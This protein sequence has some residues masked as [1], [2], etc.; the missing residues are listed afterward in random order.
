MNI[1]KLS[2]DPRSFGDVLIACSVKPVYPY[3]NG[4]RVSDEVTNL[5]YEI[6]CPAIGFEKFS[7]KIPVSAEKLDV[8]EDN[9]IQVELIDLDAHPVWTPNG[10]I[11]S[12][13]AKGIKAVDNDD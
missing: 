10:Y 4:Q 9:P 8:S 12:A 1:G 11:I 5:R 3:L 7:V 6:V 13:T 2:I